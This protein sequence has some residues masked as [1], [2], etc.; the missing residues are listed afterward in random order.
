LFEAAFANF[1]F[2]SAARVDTRNP[3]RGLLLLIAGGLDAM[4]PERISRAVH[5]RYR[6]A[7]AVTNYRV[8][9]DRG[10]SL[11]IDHG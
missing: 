11:V 1:H 10:H 4:V 3:N 7:P 5:R 8:F 6:Q 2:K 9:E